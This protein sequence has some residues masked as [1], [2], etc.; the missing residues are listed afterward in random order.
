MEHLLSTNAHANILFFTNRGKVF[1]TKVYE[2]PEASR[3][4]KGKAIA[5]ILDIQQ[6][7]TVTALVPLKEMLGKKGKATPQAIST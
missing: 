2:V 7:D 4:S 5:N 3:V 1:Q 6:Q